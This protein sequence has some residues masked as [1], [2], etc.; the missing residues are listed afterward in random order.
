MQV[1]ECTSVAVLKDISMDGL[2][3]LAECGYRKPISKTTLADQPR[4]MQMVTFHYGFLK[5]L[6]AIDQLEE[7][8]GFRSGHLL[9]FLKAL[10]DFQTYLH[11]CPKPIT[12]GEHSCV[13]IYICQ[14]KLYAFLLSLAATIV[15]FF[16]TKDF[17]E[18]GTRSH[19]LEEEAY[20]MFKDLLDEFEGM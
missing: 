19:H 11:G 5:F 10:K 16:V 1:E 9:D 12:S 2:D 3:F 7:G 6:P 13:Y 15:S 17:G 8:L 4:I 20:M 14:L 18:K